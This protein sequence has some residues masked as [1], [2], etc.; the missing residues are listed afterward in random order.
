MTKLNYKSI[1]ECMERVWVIATALLTLTAAS[2]SAPIHAASAI[3]PAPEHY[4][5]DEPGL[6]TTP[7]R[8][9]LSTLLIEH[10]QATGEQ[11]FFAVFNTL[12]DSDLT[13]R[14]H[15]VFNAWNVGKRVGDNGALLALYIK[16]NQARIE[17]GLGLDPQLPPNEN[18]R[19]IREFLMPELRAD[20][21][22]RALSLS[23]LEILRDVESPLVTTGRARQIL[24]AGGL[25]GHLVPVRVGVGTWF[26]WVLLGAVFFVFALNNLAAAEAHFTS[27]GWFRPNPW[28]QMLQ[29]IADFKRRSSRPAVG[30]ADGQW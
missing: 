2:W 4:V 23:A 18:Q 1:L 12:G 29:T 20:Q 19:L 27:T 16:E 30:G 17:V 25:E 8:N 26:V 13:V 15:E 10:D 11:I 6:L 28:R 14:T 5:L 21:P 22:Y 9:A 7:Q 24:R 3:P